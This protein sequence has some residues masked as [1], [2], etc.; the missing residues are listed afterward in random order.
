MPQK[1]TLFT[2][3]LA[4][5]LRFGNPDAS[6]ETM[7]NAA[8]IAQVEHFA[9]S[10]PEGYNTLIGSGGQG[11]SGGQMQRVSIARALVTHPALLLA[12]EPTG[13]L[14]TATSTEI[15]AL[16]GQLHRQGHTIVLVTHERD[17]AEHAHRIV[18]LRDGHIER[19]ELRH[20]EAR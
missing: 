13:N 1:P 7:Q 11:L 4:D 16:F 2:G 5:N 18:A 17:I 3:T 20:V 10:L 9:A 15:M 12:D 6:D 8:A 14:D 19:D